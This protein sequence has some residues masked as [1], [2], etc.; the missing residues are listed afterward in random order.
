M[1]NFEPL[2]EIEMRKTI[3]VSLDI[4][5]SLSEVDILTSYLELRSDQIKCG[6]IQ[7]QYRL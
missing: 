5:S 3:V 1:K 6:K 7:H 2:Q 4:I